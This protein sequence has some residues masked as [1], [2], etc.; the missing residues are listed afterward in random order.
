[1]HIDGSDIFNL[2]YRALRRGAFS[3]TDT[4][5]EPWDRDSYGIIA[6]ELKDFLGRRGLVYSSSDLF[7]LV[8]LL[9]AHADSYIDATSMSLK[10]FDFDDPEFN[11]DYYQPLK[12]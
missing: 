10:Y 1:M 6:T 8:V 4:P 2:C 5:D 7:L 9:V 12:D 3:Y 11:Q